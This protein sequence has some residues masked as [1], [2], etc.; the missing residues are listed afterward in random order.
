MGAL[1]PGGPSDVKAVIFDFYGTLVRM[2]PPLPPRH[3]TFF[4]RRGLPEAAARWGDQWSA[5]PRDGEEHLA[6][7]ADEETYTAWERERLRLRALDCG[8]PGD[9]AEE[10]AAELDRAIK[11]LRV[12]LF[13]DVRAVG[14]GRRPPPP[15]GRRGGGRSWGQVRAR[16]EGGPRAVREHDPN[17]P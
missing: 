2:V 1:R 16:G 11:R 8:V 7:S 15:P 12:E 5:G 3:D 4:L 13:P 10:L 17:T 9:Q 14:G 6:H